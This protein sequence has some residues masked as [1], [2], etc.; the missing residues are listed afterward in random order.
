[1]PYKVRNELLY[2]DDGT[3]FLRITNG[4]GTYIEFKLDA[5]V[6]EAVKFHTWY[7]DKT[8]QFA[9]ANPKSNTTM[10]LHRFVVWIRHPNAHVVRVVAPKSITP[11][12]DYRTANLN[13]YWGEETHASQSN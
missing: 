4:S 11:Y 7:W 1:M 3:P 10:K 13:I 6:V 5:E 12:Y 2:E 8:K 9:Y